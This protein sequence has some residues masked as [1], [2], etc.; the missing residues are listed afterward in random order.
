MF[1]LGFDPEN[2]PIF[3]SQGLGLSNTVRHWTPQAYLPNDIKSVESF[4]HHVHS[5]TF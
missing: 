2:V 4:K 3:W 1:W 5:L